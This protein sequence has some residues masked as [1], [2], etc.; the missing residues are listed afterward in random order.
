MQERIEQKAFSCLSEGKRVS[1]ML[2]LPSSP[3]GAVVFSH[4]FGGTGAEFRVNAAAFAREGYASALFDFRGGSP[5]S[6]SEGSASEMSVYSE[7]SD[8]L[9]VTEYMAGLGYGVP[10]LIGESLGGAVSVLTAAERG[11]IPCMVL[12][13]PA[14]CFADDV[15][16]RFSSRRLI[17]E[18]GWIDLLQ[19]KKKYCEDAWDVD[20]YAAMK[21]C[22]G[23]VLILHGTK[24]EVVPV[25]CS[26]RALGLFPQAQLLP[27]R[28]VGHRF[29]GFVAHCALRESLRF[30][31]GS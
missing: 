14:F 8:L 12:Y 7:K 31:T 5:L 28:G 24:D 30:V 20:V 4:G 26:R 27:L 25:S 19:A 22:A 1:G 15:R 23:R 29:T 16:A 2:Y 13:F 6:Q 17:G 9:A 11:D 10:V 3:R 18:G 21:K